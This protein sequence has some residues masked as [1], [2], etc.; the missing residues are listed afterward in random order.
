MS[1]L[2]KRV[3]E[4]NGTYGSHLRDLR[5]LQK[6]DMEQVS[7]D[8]KIRDTIL[9]ALEEDRIEE[10]DD[11]AF[12]ERH[13][14]AYV[15]YLGGHEAYFLGR[16][17]ERLA[18]L[19]LDRHRAYAPP[20]TRGVRGFDLLAGPQL[21][22]LLGVVAL[23]LLFGGYVAWQAMLVRTTP[24]LT[25]EEPKE[26]EP[27]RGP[28]VTVRGQTIPEASVT[29]NGRAA[30]VNAAGIF[31]LDLDVRRG[32]TAIEIIARRRRGSETRI[33]RQVSYDAPL[34]DLDSLVFPSFASSS[35]TGTR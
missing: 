21:L 9:L 2:H 26:G 14:M 34:P 19:R 25:I 5:E 16:Y 30:A 28:T 4:G 7:R 6:V 20:L 12:A 22:A 3:E 35:A 29:V 17:R 33:V 24:P 31:S 18:G 10:L 1:F 32:T 23:A 27:L 11:P 15:R 13:L 8:L